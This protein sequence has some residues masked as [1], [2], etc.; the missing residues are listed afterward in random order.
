MC[1]RDRE[2][3]LIRNVVKDMQET[4][5]QMM[6]PTVQAFNKLIMNT[7]MAGL[8]GINLVSGTKNVEHLVNHLAQN[9]MRGYYTSLTKKRDDLDKV[10][11]C[12]STFIKI[13]YTTQYHNGKSYDHDAF[14]KFAAQVLEEV[15]K[16]FGKHEARTEAGQPGNSNGQ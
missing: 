8:R 11:K 5:N 3:P 13:G 14:R 16:T 10:I 4:V 2:D 7:D 1:I 15:C 12:M 6:D 9:T